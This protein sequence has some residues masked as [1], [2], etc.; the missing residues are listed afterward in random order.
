M[1][2]FKF[3]EKYI[4]PEEDLGYIEVIFNDINK[5]RLKL[6]EKGRLVE[7]FPK[8][9]YAVNIKDINELKREI[10]ESEELSPL[11]KS[12]YL[13]NLVNRRGNLLELVLKQDKMPTL[14]GWRVL[15]TL[16]KADKNSMSNHYLINSFNSNEPIPQQYRHV[17]PC[18]C[19]HCGH[20]RERN[21]TFIIQNDNSKEYLQV[22]SGCMKDFVKDQSLQMLMLYSGISSMFNEYLEHGTKGTY[23]SYVNREK[24]LE[25]VVM[26]D[27]KLGGKYISVKNEKLYQGQVANTVV[28]NCMLDEGYF[29]DFVRKLKYEVHEENLSSSMANQIKSYIQNLTE[30]FLNNEVPESRTQKVKEL[31]QFYKNNPPTNNDNEFYINMHTLMTVD[32]PYMNNKHIGRLSYCLEYYKK[33][34]DSLNPKPEVEKKNM[35]KSE[36][37]LCNA[38]EAEEGVRIEEIIVSLENI[39]TYDSQYGTVAYHTFRTLDGKKLKWSASNRLECFPYNEY[40]D[41]MSM[42]S[43]INLNK[44]EGNKTYM[45]IACSISGLKTDQKDVPETRI[46][47]VG[48]IPN[49]K[50]EYNF[51]TDLSELT[52]DNFINIKGKYTLTEF[53]VSSIEKGFLSKDLE[54]YKITVDLKDGTKKDIFTINNIGLNEGDIIKAPIKYLGNE[55]ISLKL[56]KIKIIPEFSQEVDIEL[57]DSKYDKYNPNEEVVKKVKKSPKNN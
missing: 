12:D 40:E 56:D 37:Y 36:I 45:K 55:I 48:I 18:N 5:K 33:I 4:I 44:N 49:E 17:D 20:R 9:D 22:G 13:R 15:G 32:D 31:E 38:K 21:Q 42:L 43:K 52:N 3:E 11:Q 25:A 14:E 34:M 39:S 54:G 6:I 23:I 26:L 7:N 29:N 19:D 24:L 1:Y 2:R 53:K 16:E 46:S 27:E 30:E 51:Y 47:R 35:L 28:L 8:I 50:G 57:T 41:Y 10:K